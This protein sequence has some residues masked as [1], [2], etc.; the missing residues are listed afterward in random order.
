MNSTST[1]DKGGKG[2]VSKLLQEV[3]DRRRPLADLLALVEFLRRGERICRWIVSR[4][5]AQ[6]QDA[7]FDAAD[8][9]SEACMKLLRCEHRLRPDNTPDEKAF[10]GLFFTAALNIIR[11]RIRRIIKQRKMA[12]A[13]D[14]EPVD[15]RI[16]LER[17]CLLSEF[18]DSI[19]PLPDERRRAI[20]LWLLDYSYRE[21]AVKLNRRGVKCSH[22]SI[23][24][25]VRDAIRAF[26]NG[27]SSS[28]NKA[29]GF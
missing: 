28:I 9:F 21:I 1:S 13:S 7:T 26:K 20:V 8:L 2:N 15:R 3:L 29:A 11:S 14:A 25:W 23:Q 12:Q 6:Y 10:Y 17:S 24:R 22:T 5:Y 16:N 18:M 19:K 4:H 27:G